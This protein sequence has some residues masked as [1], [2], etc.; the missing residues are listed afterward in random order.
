M[1][2]ESDY[3][4]AKGYEAGEAHRATEERALAAEIQNHVPQQPSSHYGYRPVPVEIFFHEGEW[5]VRFVQRL[6]PNGRGRQR[7][8]AHG[9]SLIEA[10]QEARGIQVKGH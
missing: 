10:L 7:R 1:S 5:S 3:A 9:S 4:Y 6:T 2:T 8:T